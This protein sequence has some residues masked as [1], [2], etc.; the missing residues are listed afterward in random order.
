MRGGLAAKGRITERLG[1]K[2]V[3]F[4]TWTLAPTPDDGT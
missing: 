1:V 2:H 3:A 4:P